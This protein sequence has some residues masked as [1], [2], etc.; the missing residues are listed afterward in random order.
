MFLLRIT[1][2]LFFTCNVFALEISFNSAKTDDNKFS[3]IHLIDKKPF[4]CES[5]KDTFNETIEIIC[6]FSQSPSQRVKPLKDDFFTLTSKVQGKTYFII[7]RPR[8]KMKLFPMIFNL[9]KEDKFFQSSVVMSKRWMIVGYKDKMPLINTSSTP[10][11]GINL[12]I[13]MSKEMLPYVGGLDIKGNPIHFSKVQDVSDYIRIKE[14]YK[15][16]EYVK[17]LNLVN[18]TLKDYPKS[19]FKS[20]LLIY[21]I[22]ALFKLRKYEDVISDSKTFIRYFSADDAIPEILVYLATSYSKLSQFN[23]SDY[24]FD[25]LFSEYPNSYFTHLGYIYKAEQYYTKGDMKKSLHYYK[26]ALYETDNIDLAAK[27][28]FKL[29]E[30]YLD[31]KRVKKAIPFVNKILKAKSDYFYENHKNSLAMA[32]K[33]SDEKEYKTSALI[34]EALLNAMGD[35]AEEY[36]EMLRDAGLNMAK[37][38]DKD[39]AIDLLNN[40][41]KNY[42]YGMYRVEIQKAKDGLFFDNKDENISTKLD[43]YDKLME[44]YNGDSIADIALFK[45][46][47]LLYKQKKYQEVL[48]LKF[49][50]NKLDEET[51][52]GRDKLIFNSAVDETIRVLKQK[53]CSQA[54]ELADEYKIKL[55]SEFDEEFFSCALKVGNFDLA[56]SIA[57]LHVNDKNIKNRISWLIKYLHVEFNLGNYKSVIKAAKDIKSLSSVENSGDYKTVLRELFDSYQR[58]DSSDMMIKTIIEIEKAYGL[59]YKDIERYT[60]MV[61]LA[62]ELKDNSMIVSYATKVMK[63]QSRYKSYTQSPYIEFT[64]FGA[65]KELNKIQDAIETLLTLDFV[66]ITKSERARQ[67]YQ[68]G[69]LYQDENDNIK[70]KEYYERSIKSDSSSPWSSLSK[71]ALDFL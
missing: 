59:E 61:T 3:A 55:S 24:F 41:L 44:E 71:D 2:L 40:Y 15:D 7:I 17:A 48:D 6:A 1:F 29:A 58:L 60:Q 37:S 50:L 47:E 25:R 70:A 56:L 53:K 33:F 68:L 65:Y 12:P 43:D 23:D 21:R 52:K 20:E 18:D 8:E 54:L 46:A 67:E 62:S 57:K 13:I 42:K 35:K 9:Q 4:L 32:Q 49:A 30:Y 14:Y 5:Q 45:K 64:L 27:A 63:L 28:S 31:K 69:S 51:F 66:N 36:Q 22:R 16:K 38:D 34:Y 19:V 39:K 10:A 26:K 11:Q